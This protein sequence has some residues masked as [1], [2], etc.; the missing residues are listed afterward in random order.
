MHKSSNTQLVTLL[1]VLCCGSSV[2]GWGLQP[3]AGLLNLKFFSNRNGY[4]LG[5][6]AGSSGSKSQHEGMTLVPWAINF[7]LRADK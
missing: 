1:Q 5:C 7:S 2:K 6:G 4:S 3:S